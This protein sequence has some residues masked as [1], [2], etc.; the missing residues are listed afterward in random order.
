MQI[1]SPSKNME[2]E[3]TRWKF[4]FRREGKYR[5]HKNANQTTLQ[6]S[7]NKFKISPWYSWNNIANMSSSNLFISQKTN[8]LD[9]GTRRHQ[10]CCRRIHMLNLRQHPITKI[11]VPA[12]PIFKQ[13]L[14]AIQLQSLLTLIILLTS[15]PRIQ[16]H[17]K[18]HKKNPEWEKDQKIGRAHVWTPVTV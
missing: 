7:L 15:N 13:Y 14:T 2:K 8:Q 11:P 6:L 16:R 10:N 4:D 5:C 12:M 9:G 17:L 18:N 3:N 1:L